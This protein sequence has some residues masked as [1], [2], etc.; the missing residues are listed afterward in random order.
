MSKGNE[1]DATNPVV[2]LC[3]RGMEAEGRGNGGEAAALFLEA[4]HA[5]RDDYEA[6]VAAHYVARHQP[7]PAETLRWNQV[8][9]DR[10]ALVGD[11]RVAGFLSSLHLNLGQSFAAMGNLPRAGE[12]F[13]AART[14]LPAVPEGPYRN[15]VTRGV[16]AALERLPE[17]ER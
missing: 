12:H 3:A 14:N 5:A 10:A 7:D 4:W 2:Q 15:L 6:C 16:D 8:A 9:L 1:V 11:D 17:S 13:R